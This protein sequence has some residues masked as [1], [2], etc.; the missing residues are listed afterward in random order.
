MPDAWERGT[1]IDPDVAASSRDRPVAGRRVVR[2]I[3]VAALA[4]VVVGGIA[5]TWYVGALGS[6]MIVDGEGRYLGA[7]TIAE[8]SG[9]IE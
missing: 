3:L 4:L 7:V 6:A 9:V 5:Y 2:R 8:V 1:V